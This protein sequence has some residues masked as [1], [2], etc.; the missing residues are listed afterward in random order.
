MIR[1]VL[2]GGGT[3][4]HVFPLIAVVEKIR[5]EDHNTEFLYLGSGGE[6]EK[7]IMNENSI[8]SKSIMSG[9]MRRYFSFLNFLDFFKLPVGILQSLWHLLWYMPDVIFSKGGYV[10][11]PVAFAAWVYMIPILTHESDAM[12]G[13]ANRIIGKMSQRIAISYPSTRKY[14]PENHPLKFLLIV[15]FCGGFT[16]FSSFALENYNLLQNNNQI[17]AYIYMASSII[18]TITA[19]GLGSYLS[20][21]L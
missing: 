7:R 10:S 14:F 9:K 2:T 13:L 3:G 18:L 17:T 16:T 1:I 5:E 21:Y 6:L 12:P 4:G 20:K 15:G 8:P 11:V 19:V